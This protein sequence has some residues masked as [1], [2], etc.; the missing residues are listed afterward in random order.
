MHEL[1]SAVRLGLILAFIAWMVSV[2]G[3]LQ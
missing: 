3:V 1:A 2:S